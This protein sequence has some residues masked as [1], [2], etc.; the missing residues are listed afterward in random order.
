MS[1]KIIDGKQLAETIRAEIK[2]HIDELRA[3]T[4][5]I[6]GLAVILVGEN[7]ASE[8]YVR[9]K[10]KACEKIGMYSELHT[11]PVDVT[12]NVVLNKVK[13]LNEDDKI[14]GILVQLPLPEHISENII[15]TSIK[16][17]KDVDGFHP[18]NVGRLVQGAETFVPCTPLGIREMLLRSNIT[19]QGQH[20]VIVGR[21]N[22]VG[23]PLALL[24]MQKNEKGNATV[25]VCHSRTKNLREITSQADILV[26][27]I[28]K[29]EF[30]KPDMIKEGAVVID[31]GTN[32]VDDPEKPRGYR[33]T[34]DVE[35]ESVKEKAA[36]I[37][38][39]PG[40]VGPMTITM[41]LYNTLRAAAL[42][43]GK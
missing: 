21:S 30:I 28:G 34:G 19:I 18:V 3:S 38:P 14:H 43:H 1:A 35:F 13:E 29:A 23:K 15:L 7:P 6:P 4:G 2:K 37:S 17:E 33:L 31:V 36:A 42:H 32:R 41:L 20:V 16:P 5:I 10:Q 8:V 11:F 12:Q 24:L 39:V 9:N 25:T 27:A 26:A 22:I 40:G